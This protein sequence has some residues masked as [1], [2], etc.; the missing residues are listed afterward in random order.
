ML[1]ISSEKTLSPSVLKIGGHVPVLINDFEGC[2]ILI[3]NFPT[4]VNQHRSESCATA[5]DSV[6]TFLEK[7]PYTYASLV[8]FPQVVTAPTETKLITP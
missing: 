3:H 1:C 6:S 4:T 7:F 5:D 2:N 8:W